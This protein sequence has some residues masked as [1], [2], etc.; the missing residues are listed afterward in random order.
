MPRTDEHGSDYDALPECIK[1]LY[2]EREWNWMSAEQKATLIQR[3][4]E[5]EW[6][7]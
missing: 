6:E 3:D 7:E 2:S 4:T 5:P 1:Q